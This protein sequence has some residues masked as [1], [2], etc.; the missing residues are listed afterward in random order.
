MMLHEES[1]DDA[2][3]DAV[4]ARFD[5]YGHCIFFRGYSISS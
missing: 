4:I 5:F 1:D 3:S 2:V